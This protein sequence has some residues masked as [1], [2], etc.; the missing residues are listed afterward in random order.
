MSKIAF[1]S[2]HAGFGLKQDLLASIGDVVP[3]AEI[4]DLGTDRGDVS[5]DY[6]DFGAALA[7]FVGSGKADFGIAVCGTGIGISIAANRNVGARAA[8]CHDAT[9]ARL[10]RE[11]ND[12]NI[13]ALGARV[14]GGETALECVRVFLKTSFAGGRHIN[15]VAKLTAAE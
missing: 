3:G 12:A 2:D 15:R 13:L 1:A 11:H 8:L 4:I 7:D 9:T 5:V 10:A 6:P 14:M